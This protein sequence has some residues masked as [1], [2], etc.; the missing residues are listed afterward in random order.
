MNDLLYLAA[1]VVCCL[2]TFG[3]VRLCESLMPQGQPGAKR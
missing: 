1:L 3:L 2:A